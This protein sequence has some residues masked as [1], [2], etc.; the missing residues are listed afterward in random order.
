MKRKPIGQSPA[1]RSWPVPML[2]LV[3]VAGATA[4]S[5]VPPPTA[6]IQAAEQAIL[7]AEQAR[8][9]NYAATELSEA[10]VKLQ[11]AR[12]A[13]QQEK[14]MQAERLAE[15]SKLDAEL[16]L[17]RAGAADAMAVNDEMKKSTVILQQEMLRQQSGVKP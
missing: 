6:A 17:A 11:A 13:V 10:R 12:S 5:S 3:V 1:R 4:C 7:Q 2:L 15:Q 14:M 9:G 16:A 8:A